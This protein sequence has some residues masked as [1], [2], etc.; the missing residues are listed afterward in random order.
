VELSRRALYSEDDE[1][2]EEVS[3]LLR[4]LAEWKVRELDLSKEWMM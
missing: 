2:T 1:W 3:L 4:D